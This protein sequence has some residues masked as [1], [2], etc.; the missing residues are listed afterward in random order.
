MAFRKLSKRTVISPRN[1]T[2][3]RHLWIVPG[4]QEEEQEYEWS[5]RSSW[6]LTL[7]WNWSQT[8]RQKRKR[9]TAYANNKLW[10]RVQEDRRPAEEEGPEERS[11]NRR[12]EE[13][14]WRWSRVNCEERSGWWKYRRTRTDPSYHPRLL[15]IFIHSSPSRVDGIPWSSFSSPPSPSLP[16]S[17]RCCPRIMSL[18]IRKWLEIFLYEFDLTHPSCLPRSQSVSQSVSEWA[19]QTG[20]YY[21]TRFNIF[22]PSGPVS[23]V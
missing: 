1:E 4:R 8:D 17:H 2:R 15:F 12:V 18:S 19:E 11:F 16:S 10:V 21:T 13:E 9:W 7:P 5:N 22:A 14:E 20:L 23:T 6:T 3:H